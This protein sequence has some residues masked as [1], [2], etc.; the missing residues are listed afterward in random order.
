MGKLIVN[1]FVTLD[2]VIQAPGGPEEDTV[3]GFKF[4]GW[5]QPLSD[6]KAGQDITNHIAKG[7]ALLL[8]RSTY[9]NFAGYW[10]KQA[11]PIADRFNS[12]PKY[13]ASRTLKKVAWKNASILEGDLAEAVARIKKKHKEIHTWGSS[14]L[15]PTLLEHGLVDLFDLHLYPVVLGTGKRLFA[16]GIVPTTFRLKESEVYPKGA[17][18]LRYEP[19]GKP[20]FGSMG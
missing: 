4:G 10:P 1:M 7:D 15:V 5:Q 8:G 20:E 14:Q 11:G 6:E 2:G 17:I 16:E 13:V 19:A 18:H 12:I 3:G 9:D